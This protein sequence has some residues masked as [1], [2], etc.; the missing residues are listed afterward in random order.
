MLH[1]R[2]L[3]YTVRQNVRAKTSGLALES[4]ALES[5][6]LESVAKKRQVTVSTHRLY[7]WDKSGAWADDLLQLVVYVV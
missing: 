2:S 7:L 3:I 1:V 4:V 5:V 6:A